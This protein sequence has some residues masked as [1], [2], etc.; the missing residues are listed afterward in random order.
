LLNRMNLRRQRKTDKKVREADALAW[1]DKRDP[2][3]IIEGDAGVMGECL[4]WC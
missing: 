4:C 1:C 3:W 2:P